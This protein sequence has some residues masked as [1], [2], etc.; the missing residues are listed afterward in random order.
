MKCTTWM[1]LNLHPSSPSLLLENEGWRFTERILLCSKLLFLFS[2]FPY[3]FI[4]FAILLILCIL[5]T[6]LTTYNMQ[7]YYRTR[8]TKGKE[9]KEMTRNRMH[10]GHAFCLL[11]RRHLSSFSSSVLLI[12]IIISS[13]MKEKKPYLMTLLQQ[14]IHKMKQG[15]KDRG[16]CQEKF[17]LS[18]GDSWFILLLFVE[19]RTGKEILMN[20]T[21]ITFNDS[22]KWEDVSSRETISIF[23]SLFIFFHFIPFCLQREKWSCFQEWKEKDLCL[24]LSCLVSLYHLYSALFDN[25]HALSG[26]KK[27]GISSGISS[28]KLPK[29]LPSLSS[30]IHRD[31]LLHNHIFHWINL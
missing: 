26:R 20:F 5:L 2:L 12:I 1:S 17:F 14:K 7:F 30:E 19:S 15:E 4:A 21:W 16:K 24:F 10:S 28:Q 25:S 13:R 6:A 8:G 9:E 29:F 18:V 3:L 11:Q 22:M 23:P 31:M 27:Q